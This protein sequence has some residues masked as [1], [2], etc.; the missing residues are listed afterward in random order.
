VRQGADLTVVREWL[1]LMVINVQHALLA[2]PPEA[3]ARLQGEA[4]GYLKLIRVL[5]TPVEIKS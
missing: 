3:V 2:A 5:S 4:S 1:E